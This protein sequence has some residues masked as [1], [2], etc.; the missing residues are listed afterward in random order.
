MGKSEAESPPYEGS[1][2]VAG[3]RIE[4]RW[5]LTDEDEVARTKWWGAS[6]VSRVSPPAEW[7]IRYD[8]SEG[9]DA[10]EARVR[11]LSSEHLERVEDCSDEAILRWRAEGEAGEGDDDEDEEGLVD[12]RDLAQEQD[13]FER[14][15]GQS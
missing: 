3:K 2:L 5:L 14:E 4:V 8:P 9:F 1:D 15:T 12:L 10:E 13:E 6:L 7:N 11:F